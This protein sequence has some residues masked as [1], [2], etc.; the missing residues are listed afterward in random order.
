MT[1]E[2]W[3]IFDKWPKGVTIDPHPRKSWFIGWFAVNPR[4]DIILF[5]EWPR[6]E[7][8]STDVQL[9]TTGY[10]DLIRGIEAGDNSWNHPI[11]NVMWRILDPNFGKTPSASSGLTLQRELAQLGMWFDCN[12]P[13]RVHDRHI[14]VQ[15]RL[16]RES[17][18]ITPN[19]HN[20]ILAMERYIHE[21]HKRPDAKNPSEKPR[22][23]YK[24]GADV[25]GYTC[26]MNPTYFTPD[27]GEPPD[28]SPMFL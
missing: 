27:T 13:D 10:L 9:G 17:L 8:Y 21:E 4:N 24:D 26:I 16:E 7:Y 5:E 28:V 11:T 25:A 12:V 18:I 1:P 22:E 2:Q 19:C 14:V 20:L 3:E 15:G 23:A 6:T